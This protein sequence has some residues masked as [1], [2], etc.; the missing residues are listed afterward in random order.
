MFLKVTAAVEANAVLDEQFAVVFKDGTKLGVTRDDD[1]F[2][3]SIIL[4][5]R[6]YLSLLISNEATRRN[7]GEGCACD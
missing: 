3:C 7:G 2:W 4:T 6:A 1:G 5:K